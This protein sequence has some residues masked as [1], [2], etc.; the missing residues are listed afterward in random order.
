MN[1]ETTAALIREAVTAARRDVARLGRHGGGYNLTQFR[2]TP[3]AE[4]TSRSLRGTRTLRLIHT[5]YDTAYDRAH[6]RR[7]RANA[8][9]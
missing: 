4:G 8:D 9:Q 2:T 5:V 6:D 1:D 7:L 3:E